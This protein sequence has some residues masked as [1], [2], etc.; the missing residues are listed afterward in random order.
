MRRVVQYYLLLVVLFVVHVLEEVWGNAWFIESLYGNLQ[1]FIL[2]NLL[3]L[4]I[5]LIIFYFIVKK[6][7]WA[8]Y[9]GYG[10]AGFMI[11]NGLDHI[12]ELILFQRYVN[13][14]AGLF[15]GILFIPIGFLLIFSLKKRIPKKKN[16]LL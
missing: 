1:V 4:I 2:A 11:L 3:F 9:L 10:F 13:G 12:V 6:H 8:F 5:P 16:L 7:R 15:S 14:A